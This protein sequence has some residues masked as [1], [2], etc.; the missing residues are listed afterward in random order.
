MT[1]FMDENELD[2][3][4]EMNEEAG[5][6]EEAEL[7][8]IEENSAQKI[9]EIK[10]KLKECEKEKMDALEDLQRA[11]ADF[12]NGKRR[13]EEERSRDKERAIETQIEKL[14][15][16]C[17]G[18]MMAMSDKAAWEAIDATWRKG[19]ESIY[20]QLQSILAS[21][22]VRTIDPTGEAF[23]PQLHEAM[24]NV[25]VETAAEHH[26]VISVLQY[27][28]LREIGGKTELLRPA[29]VTVGEYT[30]N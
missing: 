23:D 20:T 19:I 9:K 4:L 28:Y 18:F 25:P 10:R 17:D 1:D 13:L 29:R 24:A 12:L 15:P 7:E 5:E 30:G 16:L 27:G 21:Y 22:N 3:T 11:K 26:R 6:M 2:E 14:L 8:D